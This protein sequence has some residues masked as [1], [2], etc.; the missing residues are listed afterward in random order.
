MSTIC[1]AENSGGKGGIAGGAGVNGQASQS[2]IGIGSSDYGYPVLEC[3][4]GMTATFNIQLT[5][6]YKGEVQSDLSDVST[7]TFVAR[8][9]MKYGQTR[10]ISV[11]CPFTSDGQVTLTLTPTEVNHNNGVWFAEFLCKK[12][13]DTLVQDHRAYLCIR[14]G[15]RGS[16]SE[17]HTI[18]PMDVRLALMDTSPEANTLL[19]DL[20]F[21]DMMILNAVERSLD[22]WNETPPQLARKY[23]ATNF[24]YREHLIKGAVGYLMESIAYRYIRNR[25]Q[26]QAS[27]LSL[28]S[29][30]KGPQYL[31][32]ANMAR[33]EWKTFIAAAKT[34]ENMNETFGVIDLP[35]F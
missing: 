11:D 32:L 5:K 25:M 21:S 16:H 9:T 14:K 29:S 10:E 3:T 22:E 2:A 31:Q 8:P 13:D 34:A 26:Y 18:T 28:D 30:D 33:T 20:E 17:V 23:D 7:V 4:T 19:D 15:T 6:D 35:W 27:G 24:P 12:A 1:I